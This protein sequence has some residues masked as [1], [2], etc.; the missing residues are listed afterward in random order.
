MENSAK[1]LLLGKTGVG[2]SSFINYFLGKEL[3][4][5]G[6]G[7]PITQEITAYEVDDGRYPI[8]IF[9]SKGIEA[10]TANEQ[11]NDI[12]S[13]RMSAICSH[14]TRRGYVVEGGLFKRK[15]R[16]TDKGVAAIKKYA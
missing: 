7:K 6:A 3:A 15:L 5:T 12:K 10:K 9:D 16:V 4:K 8:E 11:K 13:M 1:I 14:L 2:K